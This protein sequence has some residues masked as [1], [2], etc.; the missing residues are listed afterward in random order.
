MKFTEEDNCKTC[1]YGYFNDFSW[2]GYHNLC[3]SPDGYC[4]LC[5]Q[6]WGECDGYEKGDIP[7]GKERDI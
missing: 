5:Q 3:G 4:Y 2:D 1:K 7:E 6:K